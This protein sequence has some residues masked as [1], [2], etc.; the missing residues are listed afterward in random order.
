[1]PRARV[2]EPIPPAVTTVVTKTETREQ[3]TPPPEEARVRKAPL[4]EFMRTLNP[5]EL[6]NHSFW[7]YRLDEGVTTREGNKY[8]KRLDSAD[9]N[10]MTLGDFT[11]SLKD[12]IQNKANAGKGFG[13]GKFLLK[14][15]VKKTGD[16][17]YNEVFHLEGQP[18]LSEREV[19]TGSRTQD[20]PA[21]AAALSPADEAMKNAIADSVKRQLEGG[22]RSIDPMEVV[23]QVI[24]MM[25]EANTASL[26]IA[27][28]QVAPA[29][30]AVDPM[31][32]L[33]SIITVLKTLG[34]IGQ[35]HSLKDMIEELR[36][37]GLIQAPVPP[38]PAQNP[39]TMLKDTLTA[40]KDF[41][42]LS[43]E[44]SNLS[45]EGGGSSGLVEVMKIIPTALDKLPAVLDKLREVRG[46]RAPELGAAHGAPPN[47]AVVTS[48]PGGPGFVAA[49]A[50]PAATPAAP[51]PQELVGGFIRTRMV[52]LFQ[53]GA[54]GDAVA[55][56]LE[57]CDPNFAGQLGALS[58]DILTQQV[59]AKD[60]IL[61]VAI[62]D[63][64]LPAFVE[65]F[66][67]YFKADEEDGAPVGAARAN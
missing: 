57:T 24:A 3:Q 4:D 58:P 2:Q 19:F 22:N 52:Q 42:E 7:L 40:I 29:S 41:R 9:L 47:A 11:E 1:M 64:R 15:N 26:A 35:Q 61:R 62:G 55:E 18:V 32:L 13:G 60:P 39:I 44:A 37:L 17:L 5:L 65:S 27:T 66:L 54:P 49:G 10:Q 12:W 8:L 31:M 33:T 30:A 67:S 21:A 43:G 48:A 34:L 36:A 45:G 6:E 23:R 46:A 20:Q 53:S 63:P 56:W 59:I 14:L 51:A 38:V 50:P 28:K 25:Q 16:N